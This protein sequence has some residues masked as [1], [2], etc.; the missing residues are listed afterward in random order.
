[1]LKCK[2]LLGEAEGKGELQ[3]SKGGWTYRGDFKSNRPD[4]IGVREYEDGGTYEGSFCNGKFHGHGKLQSADG[5]LYEGTWQHGQQHGEGTEVLPSG[6][7][8]GAN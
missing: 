2:F 1:M 8:Q 7:I 5:Y 4:G 3:S 6:Q